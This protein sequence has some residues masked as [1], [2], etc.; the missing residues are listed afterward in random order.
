LTIE[1]R[2][3]AAAAIFQPPATSTQREKGVVVGGIVILQM[4]RIGG[5]SAK[6]SDWQ[7][8]IGCP[9][10]MGE[11]MG[12]ND[13]QLPMPAPASRDLGGSECHIAPD[14]EKETNDKCK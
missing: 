11:F 10:R 8:G 3:I 7:Q 14:R 4:D 12:R 2:S 13:N 9:H 1:R 6:R 5:R